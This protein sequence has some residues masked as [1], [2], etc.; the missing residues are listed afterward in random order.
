MEND[1]HDNQLINSSIKI[2]EINNSIQSNNKDKLILNNNNVNKEKNSE[3]INN[4]NEKNINNPKER[5]IEKI[6]EKSILPI[7]KNQN[8]N[9]L[10]NNSSNNFIISL[11][12]ELQKNLKKEL[13]IKENDY[14]SPRK[15]ENIELE[16]FKKTTEEF[17]KNCM[18]QLKKEIDNYDLLGNNLLLIST[19]ENLLK[20]NYNP[21]YKYIGSVIDN[22]NIYEKIIFKWRATK[23]DNDSY[24]RCIMFYYIENIIFENNIQNLINLFHDIYTYSKEDYFI[25]LITKNNINFNNVYLTLFL[26]YYGL[27]L[28]DHNESV[29]KPYTILI[30]SVNHLKDFDL[31]IILYLKYLLYKY[32]QNN[33]EKYYS[34]DISIKIHDLLPKNYIKDGKFLFKEFY[35][36][37]LIP[38]N[39]EP[40]KIVIYMLPL[41]LGKTIKIYSFDF[42]NDLNTLKELLFKSNINNNNESPNNYPICLFFVNSHY[43][44]LYSKNYYEEYKDFLCKY[45]DNSKEEES[46][47][48]NNNS[49]LGFINENQSNNQKNS[50]KNPSKI[51]PSNI[52]KLSGFDEEEKKEKYNCPIC[53]IQIKKNFC[54]DQCNSHI[55]KHWLGASYSNFIKFNIGNLI[56]LE[57]ILSF[58][59]F[60][61]KYPVVNYKNKFKKNFKEGYEYLTEKFIINE[62]ILTLK[63]SL[64][65]G[66]FKFF[67][68]LDNS[69][70]YKLPCKCMFCSMKCIKKFMDVISFNKMNF[71]TCACGEE[72]DFIKLKYFASFLNSLNFN[73]QKNEVIKYIHNIM[74]NKCA[75]CNSN[76]NIENKHINYIEVF[77]NEISNIF[78]I[79]KFYHLICDNC[80]EGI[81]NNNSK[82][83]CEICNSI[84]MIIEKK[85]H[86]N[87][88]IN[89]YCF[90]F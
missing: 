21:N 19:L 26:I 66:C 28:R 50:E 36:N 2:E 72:Y 11:I 71:F 34:K 85:Y 35:K 64:C 78:D 8:E 14:I 76:I 60:I 62:Y 57:K 84:H 20:K 43:D 10:I 58:P 25:E 80:W 6:S 17:D 56:K 55:L 69:F 82:F 3:K 81:G 16:K 7:I 74:K 4:I 51:L 67:S 44:I 73:N 86:K 41:A 59:Q 24:Y 45:L 13:S 48:K 54:C 75:K 1:I 79:N 27:H 61:E 89:D 63:N 33:E 88:N 87:E 70:I 49:N 31:G 29:V 52:S 12:D 22:L 30:K 32:I 77:D 18:I 53:N 40:Q 9:N 83:V 15:M 37:E 23:V 68:V 38:F 46:Y 42:E 65:L 47:N 90:M 5:I 39:K